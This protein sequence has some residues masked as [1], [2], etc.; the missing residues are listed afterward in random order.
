MGT[1]IDKVFKQIEVNVEKSL[2]KVMGAKAR[3]KTRDGKW[4][5]LQRKLHKVLNSTTPLDA[6]VLKG[7]AHI[8][9]FMYEAGEEYMKGRHTEQI[10]IV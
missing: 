1:E 8:E 7:E 4:M 5:D 2:G 10:M 6:R 9:G 3:A